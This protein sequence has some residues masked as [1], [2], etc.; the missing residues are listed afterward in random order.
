MITGL[1][2]RLV[3]RPRHRDRDALGLAAGD[4]E[5]RGSLSAD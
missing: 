5:R 3:H 2:E 4:P 1:D